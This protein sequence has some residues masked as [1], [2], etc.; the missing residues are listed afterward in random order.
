MLGDLRKQFPKIVIDTPP[1]FGGSEALM[2]AKQSDAV[3]VSTMCNVS[4]IPQVRSA[5]E[6]L[7][8][9]GANVIGSVLNGKSASGYAYSYGYGSYSGRL[10]SHGG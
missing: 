5:V 2:L 9:A 8:H 1:I 4:R 10:E 3:L 6:R 7:H